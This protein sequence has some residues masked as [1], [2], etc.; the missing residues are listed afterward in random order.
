MRWDVDIRV[1][2]G[3][4]TLEAQLSGDA[5]TLAVI[6]P[7]GSGKTTMIRALAGGLLPTAGAIRLQGDPTRVL[8]DATAGI[9][10]APEERR[11]GYVPQG[12]SLFPHLDV[13]DNVSFGLLSDRTLTRA[14]RRQKAQAFLESLGHEA[15]ALLPTLG[16]SGGEAQRIALAR[17]LIIQPDLLLLDEPLAAMDRGS[18]PELRRWLKEELA[19]QAVPTLLVTHDLRDVQALA[20][21]VAL[22]EDGQVHPPVDVADL[23]STTPTNFTREFFGGW[24]PI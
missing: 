12:R 2:L 19:R 22:V 13:L 3:T 8:F 18:R 4:F 17:A 20:N 21:R 15:L 6:G 11:V 23:A 1:E 16:L 7:N 24:E 5:E 9:A 14:E 10:V